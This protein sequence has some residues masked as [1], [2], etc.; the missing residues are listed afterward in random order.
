MTR[1]PTKPRGVDEA[2]DASRRTN[3]Q[4]KTRVAHFRF[5]PAWRYSVVL[6]T[7]RANAGSLS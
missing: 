3:P 2:K 6:P 1:K 7:S 4:T 5:L